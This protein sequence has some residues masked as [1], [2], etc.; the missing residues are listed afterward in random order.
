MPNANLKDIQHAIKDSVGIN[1]YNS[2]EE[3]NECDIHF[4]F[5]ERRISCSEYC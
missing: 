3:T 1:I 4:L 5:T 2:D